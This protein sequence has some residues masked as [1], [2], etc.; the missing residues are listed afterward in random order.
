MQ[1]ATVNLFADMGVQPATLQAGLVAATR[2]DRRHR[3]DVDDHVAGRR[4]DGAVRTAGHHHRHRD[5]AGGG[6]VGGVEVSVDG[7]TT[8]HPRE[9]PRELDLHLDAARRRA[10]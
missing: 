5:R 10:R 2:V 8:W 6:V 4:R 7:G 1:Q 3:A 9:R